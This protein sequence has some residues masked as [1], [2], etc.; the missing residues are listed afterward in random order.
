MKKYE[1]GSFDFL[2]GLSSPLIKQY[3]GRADFQVQNIM[4]GGLLGINTEKFPM[5]NKEFRKAVLQSLNP[6][7]LIPADSNQI[8]LAKTFILPPLP[9]SQTPNKK[10]KIRILT[11]NSE[12]YFTI[13]KLIQAQIQDT[14][15]LNVELV[16]PQSQE[17]TAYMD[18]GDYNATLLTWTAKVLSPQ[19]FLLPYSGDASYNRM[20]FVNPFYD[21]WIFEGARS[22]NPKEA[23]TAFFEAQKVI[24]IDDAVAS[25]L[26]SETSANLV[27]A[28]LKHL[29]F[30]HMGIPILKDVQADGK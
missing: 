3:K 4:R 26:F 7:K 21:Q 6:E 12:P 24:A 8:H 22:T 25:P 23:Q 5:S 14:L 28:K 20:H 11:S 17:Y 1:E 18:L 2:W 27:R 10:L 29:Y 30:N 19:D 16:A 9:G 15:G 13:T